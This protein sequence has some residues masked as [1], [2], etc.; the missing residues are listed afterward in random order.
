[1]DPDMLF[2]SA[3]EPANFDEASLD[4]HWQE[5][6]Q[7]EVE[8]IEKNGTWTLTELPPGHKPIGLR[9]V[10]KVKKDHEGKILKYKARIVAK[11][12][13]QR[14]GIDYDEVFAP[15]ARLDTIRLILAMAA[16]RRWQVHH[17]DV[18]SAFLNGDLKEE[19]YVAQPPGF[20]NK[21]QEHKV[22]RLKKALYGLKQAPRTW[23]QHLD[24]CLKELGFKRCTQ[25]Q[26]VYTRSKGEDTLI[27]GVYVDDLI[28]TGS[29]PSS[30]SLYKQQMKERFDMSD[31][32]HLSYYLGLEVEQEAGC[33]KLK[34]T[35]Y[36]K[37]ILQQFGMEDCN[38]NKY[39]M[40]PKLKLRKNQ[41]GEATDPTH[42]R[43]IIGSL[44]YLTHTRPDLAYC[45]GLMSRYMEKPKVEHLQAVKQILRYVKGTTE[46]GLRYERRSEGEELCG[47]T[48]SNLAGDVDDRK[49]TS[50]MAYYYN[51]N[52][53][54]WASQKQKTVAL[55]SCE[56]EFMAAT[57]AACQ[58][59]WLK[60]LISEITGSNP[61]PVT[62]YIDNKSAIALMKNPVFHGRSK[63]IDT[64]YH[65]IRE[66]VERGKILVEFVRTQEQ[67]ADIL[68][69]ALARIKFAEMQQKLGIV[70]LEHAKIKEEI[71]RN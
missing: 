41:E 7:N 68:T 48:D 2:L 34:Q 30:L 57:S 3:E 60:N 61:K 21:N 14:Q 33:I 23:N 55:S 49:S 1:M 62:I 70:N 40:E 58:A 36:A 65:F 5:A 51:N 32:G 16:Q 39:P 52:L 19:V 8:A 37:R 28:V 67:R 45:V 53:I 12:Y 29:C 27:V 35:A 44:R 47:Y 25:E 66:C 56:A 10:Y 20:I 69:K 54:T 42:Y 31:L 17:L 6:M 46:F 63:H 38:P 71:V 4:T 59:L 18:K 22:Y 26:A 15:V 13:V 50:G 24:L 64:R 43:R 9:W 11:G